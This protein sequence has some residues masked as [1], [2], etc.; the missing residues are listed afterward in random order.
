M[1]LLK[2]AAPILHA[3]RNVDISGISNEVAKN[4]NR[5]NQKKIASTNI[6]KH[7]LGSGNFFLFFKDNSLVQKC[8][9]ISGDNTISIM[10]PT[11]TSSKLPAISFEKIFDL[12][13]K[14]ASSPWGWLETDEKFYFYKCDLPPIIADEEE[15]SNCVPLMPMTTECLII[16]KNIGRMSLTR[17]GE[18]IDL[19][20]VAPL[21]F[22]IEKQT[23]IPKL[24]NVNN[25]IQRLKSRND[26]T[27]NLTETLQFH[28]NSI[29]TLGR[30]CLKN[31]KE[32][33]DEKLG[34]ALIF[35]SNQ[36]GNWVTKCSEYNKLPQFVP[37]IIRMAL[38]VRA[39][40]K[41]AYAV[42]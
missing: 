5:G 13:K 28:A 7:Q 18:N 27:P 29:E 37:S 23:V 34:S 21:D 31:P 14:Q 17:R 40:S 15:I 3:P 6:H 25:F 1:K 41:A 32:S 2:H 38:L 35:I 36:L 19:H 33:P 20:L 42:S 10:A 4:R 22:D 8:L 26:P 11:S 16:N 12:F 39:Q 9:F 24:A 30:N